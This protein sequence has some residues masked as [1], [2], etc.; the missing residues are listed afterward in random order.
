MLNKVKAQPSYSFS[1][2]MPTFN[3]EKTVIR[4]LDSVMRQSYPVHEIIVV[5]DA[6]SDNTINVINGYLNQNSVPIKIICL[7]NNGGPARARNIGWDNAT[8]EYVAFIDSD[9]TW[10]VKKLEIQQSVMKIFPETV[11]CGVQAALMD[12]FKEIRASKFDKFCAR[13]VSLNSILFQN[14]YSTTS[15]VVV[16]RSIDLRFNVDM[17][18]GEDYHLWLNIISNSL[19]AVKIDCVL[20]Y[21]HKPPWGHSGLSAS[22][23]KMEISEISNIFSL[24]KQSRVSFSLALIAF[25]WSILKFSRRILIAMIRRLRWRKH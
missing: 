7:T 24:V 16:L 18:Y 13:K 23:W 11:L 12:D 8:G 25:M 17:R 1:V 5:D 21:Y 2:V 22:L 15:S 3:S 6:S 9:D 20:S 4:A 14:H 19:A 10:S